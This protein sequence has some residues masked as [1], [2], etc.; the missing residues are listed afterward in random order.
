MLD[1]ISDSLFALCIS[2]NKILNGFFSLSYVF[3]KF[4]IFMGNRSH[5]Y[6][7]SVQIIIG[8]R[9]FSIV[10]PNY[11]F[12]EFDLKHFWRFTVL[13]RSP[14][15]CSGSQQCMPYRLFQFLMISNAWIRGTAYWWI[16]WNRP[17][18]SMDY[19]SLPESFLFQH[20]KF[21]L[22]RCSRFVEVSGWL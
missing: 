2:V 19:K 4:D 5:F 16:W 1:K 17:K 12:K 22:E 9:L 21:V 15:S 8:R 11:I 13:F 3:L 18:G 7:D 20:L 14:A 6:I 10:K